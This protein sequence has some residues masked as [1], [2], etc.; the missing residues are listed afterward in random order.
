MMMPFTF[1]FLNVHRLFV[2]AIIAASARIKQHDG[3]AVSGFH[4]SS[5]TTL[6][7]LASS[8]K[9]RSMS[10]HQRI[11]TTTTMESPATAKFDTAMH[12]GAASSFNANE[13]NDYV[14]N[15]H[16]YNY[17]QLLL[18]HASACA[19]SDTCSIEYA[20]LYLKEIFRLQVDCAILDVE[21]PTATYAATA[22]TS[23]V[24][25]MSVDECNV[26]NLH[27]IGEI[28]AKL[29]DKIYHHHHHDKGD[30]KNDAVITFWNQRQVELERLASTADAA[31][32][33]S[34][35]AP[36]KPAYLAIAALYS[37]AMMHAF[38]S[39]PPS[40]LESAPIV[41]FTFKEVWYA[42]RDGYIDS[43]IGHWFRNGGLSGGGNADGAAVDDVTN[44]LFSSLPSAT[45]AAA[46]PIFLSPQEVFWSI[47]DGYVD[48]TFFSSSAIALGSSIGD[49]AMIPFS[50]Q[51]VWWAV[52]GRYVSDLVWHWFRNGGLSVL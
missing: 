3:L 52:H 37:M 6:R 11:V 46:H 19:I 31:S 39:T 5:P 27:A 13:K 44:V 14:N 9:H 41:P 50:P 17:P 49:A 28:V 48:D 2:L 10:S 30:G 15:G 36:L 34:F 42:I 4:L 29:K 22:A 43:L 33:T 32:S 16:N 40:V 7:L 8:P 51:E 1:S 47:R 45:S 20:E 38:H 18:D 24:G 25:K 23:S 26:E 21:L 12:V 35:A